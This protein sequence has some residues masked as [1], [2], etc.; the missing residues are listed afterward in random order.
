M[1]VTL[2]AL[3]SPLAFAADAP[4]NVAAAV[5]DTTRPET[6]TKRDADRKPAEVLAF[7]GVKTG[8]KVLDLVAGGGYFSR[9]FA[10]AVGPTGAVYMFNPTEF[11]KNSKNPVPANGSKP[12]PAHPNITFVNTSI[13]ELKAPEKVDIVWTSQNYHD[14]HKTYM[15]EGFDIAKFNK[16]V[17]DQLKPGGTF[18]VLDHSAKAGTGRADIESL[19]RIDEATVKKEV[20]AAGFKY[21]GSLDVLRNKSDDR[22]AKVFDP[23]IRS[24]TDQF[25]LKFRKPN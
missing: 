4:K 10:G 21:E 18:I 20:E 22:S 25:V 13:N 2:T 3:T 14:L 7:T 8:D 1:L 9:L 15:G 19:H 6:D 23:A 17:F 5:A 24:K 12:D 16:V 11:T